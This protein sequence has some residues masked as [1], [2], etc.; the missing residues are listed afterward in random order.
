MILD[1]AIILF[2]VSTRTGLFTSLPGAKPVVVA[3]AAAVVEGQ[4]SVL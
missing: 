4:A 2:T 3:A 1:L